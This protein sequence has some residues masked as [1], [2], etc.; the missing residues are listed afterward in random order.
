MSIPR[1]PKVDDWYEDAEDGRWFRIV[2]IDEDEGTIEVQYF[3][4][5]V[6]EFE[7]DTWYQMD[8]TRVAEPEDGSGPFDD[9]EADDLGETYRSIRPEDWNGPA[10]E[11]DYEE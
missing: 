2:A 1:R 11:M 3:D 5:D 9:L 7:T 6:Q 10:D 4:G 8:L